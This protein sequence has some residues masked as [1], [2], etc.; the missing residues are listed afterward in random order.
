MRRRGRRRLPP[1]RP[2][3]RSALGTFDETVDV[4]LEGTRREQAT[5]PDRDARE[6]M[7]VH[8]EIERAA[9]NPERPS[10]LGYRQQEVTGG[11]RTRVGRAGSR[12]AIGVSCRVAV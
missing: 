7:T 5:A 6:L 8:K 10:R 2:P 9:G 3:W 11:H 4:L 12:D 1:F